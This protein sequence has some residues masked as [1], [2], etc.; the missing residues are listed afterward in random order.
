M[1][2]FSKNDGSMDSKDRPLENEP[3][4]SIV[5]KD[6]TISG[7]IFFKGK[8]RV[9]GKVEG[10]IEG[11]YLILSETGKVLG[12]V[13]GGTFVCQGRVDGDVNVKNLYV[14]KGGTLNGKLETVDILVESGASLNGE[15]KARTQDLRLV[16][17][18][19]S[20][21]AVSKKEA[22]AAEGQPASS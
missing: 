16:Q 15:I 20:S 14:K 19:T 17:K 4:T 9:D 12:D 21:K 11:E 6:M 5:G 8:A 10:N 1:G 18:T 13:K 22:I 7:N 2:L 3:I